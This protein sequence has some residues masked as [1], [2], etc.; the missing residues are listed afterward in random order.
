M[1][2]WFHP[3]GK[4]EVRQA[5]A[6]LHSDGIARCANPQCRVKLTVARKSERGGTPRSD[7]VAVDHIDARA[8]GGSG[9]P[10]M[11]Q[12]VCRVHDGERSDGPASWEI[13]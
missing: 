1:D 4:D 8:H 13:H 6:S 9:D 11:G 12:Y 7:E 2:L 5:A 10:S 3:A